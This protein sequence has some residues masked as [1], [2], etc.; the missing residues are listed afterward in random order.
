MNRN[1]VATA[2]ERPPE[3]NEQGEWMCQVCGRAFRG[4]QSLGPHQLAHRR[5]VG[6]SP[7][8]AGHKLNY[9]LRLAERSVTC[10]LPDCDNTLSY[11]SLLQ[12]LHKLHGLTKTEA[13]EVKTQVRDS[14]IERLGGNGDQPA[15]TTLAIADSQPEQ[16]PMFNAN[17]TGVGAVTGI[18]NAAKRDGQIPVVMLPEIHEWI[19]MTSHVLARLEKLSR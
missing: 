4:R 18:L 7:P 14:L 12:H 3:Q 13:W 8:R 11:R 1:Q 10:P 5:E 2:L 9:G 17:V 6:L 16:E 19:D 15:S